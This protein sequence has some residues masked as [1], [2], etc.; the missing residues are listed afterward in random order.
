MQGLWIVW[1][2][3]LGAAKCRAKGAIYHLIYNPVGVSILEL[4]GIDPCTSPRLSSELTKL[5]ISVYYNW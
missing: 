2:R 1:E 4:Q 5:S 3:R